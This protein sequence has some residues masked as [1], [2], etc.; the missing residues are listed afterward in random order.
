MKMPEK[1]KIVGYQVTISEVL[2]MVSDRARVG[3]YSPRTQEIQI[4]STF[5]EQYKEEVLIH[6]ILEAIKSLFDLKIPHDALS[7]LSIVLH[8][9]LKDNDLDFHCSAGK[10]A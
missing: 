10:E 6:E 8:Q 9:V 3:E 2:D 5:T 7:T 4:E 1:I